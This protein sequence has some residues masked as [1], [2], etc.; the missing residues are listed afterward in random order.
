MRTVLWWLTSYDTGSVN[1][2]KSVLS[3]AG[4]TRDTKSVFKRK[5]SCFVPFSK[6]FASTHCFRIVFAR[7]H[8]NAVSVLKTRLYPQCACSNEVDACAFQYIGPRNWRH[9]WFFVVGCCRGLEFFDIFLLN[10]AKNSCKATQTENRGRVLESRFIF[11]FPWAGKVRS[12]K[13]SCFLH[14]KSKWRFS[15]V[16]CAWESVKRLEIIPTKREA[17]CPP[18]WILTVGWSGAPSCLMTSPFF[19]RPH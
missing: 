3:L 11:A 2:R 1:R 18:F 7:P 17:T 10:D 9:S 4:F 12:L 14:V 8:Y 15:W 6:R 16:K 13:I 19:L 5:R